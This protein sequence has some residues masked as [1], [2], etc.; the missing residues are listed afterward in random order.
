MAMGEKESPKPPEKVLKEA[1]FNVSEKCYSRPSCFDYAAR[2]NDNLII[3]K[4]QPDIRHLCSNDF[5]ALKTISETVSA[6]SI[7]VS[8]RTHEK[9]FED[10]TVY[11][12]YG[13]LAITSKTFENIILYEVHPLIQAGPG[14]YYVEVDGATIKRGRQKLGYSIGELAE[15]V[16]ISRRTLYGYEHGLAKATVPAA[17]NLVRVLGVPIAKPVNI[18]EK[19]KS[20]HKC[21]FTSAKRAIARSKFLRK[22]FRKLSCSIVQVEKAPFDFVI[23]IP[24]EKTR[25]IGGVADKTEPKLDRRVDEILSVSKIIQAHPLLIAEDQKILGK[26]ISCVGR[27]EFSKIRNTEDLIEVIT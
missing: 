2:K 20:Q 24:E 17:Y 11:T 9:P 3:V 6:A 1:G 22:I 5:L 27:E 26:H 8:D 13:V 23:N 19:P 12:R 15:K 25:I 10:D 7:I 18:F 14:G 21:I 16:G 4:A